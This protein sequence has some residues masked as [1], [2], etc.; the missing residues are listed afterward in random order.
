MLRGFSGTLEWLSY[1]ETFDYS[2]KVKYVNLNSWF[3]Y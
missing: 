1:V 3:F 2:I